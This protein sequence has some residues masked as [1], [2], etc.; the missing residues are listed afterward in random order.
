[1]AEVEIENANSTAEVKKIEFKN[2][3]FMIGK[4]YHNNYIS[5]DK[6]RVI[7]IADGFVTFKQIEGTPG[8]TYR[9]KIHVCNRFDS[10]EGVMQFA[11]MNIGSVYAIDEV[12]SSA[13]S[14]K[15]EETMAERIAHFAKVLGRT[16]SNAEIIACLDDYF[17]NSDDAAE[18]EE[19]NA[20][21]TTTEKILKILKR[22]RKSV[23][24]WKAT[25]EDM[26]ISELLNLQKD[27]KKYLKLG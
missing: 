5:N 11:K 8:G 9:R 14:D 25:F 4:V 3:T 13:E 2:K 26:K 22:P 12:I 1:M 16:D 18:V 27:F 6:Y 7:K 24:D 21:N 20:E 10:D 23:I 19:I 15:K 17:V